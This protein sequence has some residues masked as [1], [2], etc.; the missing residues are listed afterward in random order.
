MA[1][2]QVLVSSI[3][4]IGDLI[5][6]GSARNVPLRRPCERGIVDSNVV[7]EARR[8]GCGFDRFE[9]YGFAF[10]SNRDGIPVKVK[11][12]GQLHRL[13]SISAKDLGGLHSDFQSVWGN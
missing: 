1:A 9:D 10:P 11:S 3:Y 5:Q 12:V 6:S 8:P 13:R 2:M 4:R 7:E